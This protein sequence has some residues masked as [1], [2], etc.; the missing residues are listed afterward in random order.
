MTDV[1]RF[2]GDIDLRLEELLKNGHV[3]LPSLKIFDI[4]DIAS[5]IIADMNEST[6][7]ELGYSHKNFLATL[8]IEKHLT[9]KL[10]DIATNYMGYKGD[11]KNQ[12]H[13]ARRV[14]PGNTKEMYRAHFDSHLFTLVLPLRIPALLNKN[15]VGDLIYFPNER[16]A[17]KSEFSNFISKAYYK[18]YASKSGIEK[19]LNARQGIT[20]NFNDYKPLLFIGNTTLHTNREVS[21]DCSS[22]RLT[23]LAHFFD[24]S[25]KYGIG[26]I[27]RWLRAR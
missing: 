25:P 7:A 27:V 14:E 10:F 9:P 6:F 8:E 5:N 1:D 18:K 26:G 17:P 13:I 11:A 21:S 3:K 20:D 2:W 19:L 15:A 4:D 24:P 23:L 22:N 12:Y 16:N